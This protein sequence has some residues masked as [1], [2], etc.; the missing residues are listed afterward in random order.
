MSDVSMALAEWRFKELNRPEPW[1]EEA[2]F[3]R[4]LW[5]WHDGH[6]H[7]KHF[8]VCVTCMTLMQEWQEEDRAGKYAMYDLAKELGL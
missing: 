1:T 3:E 6:S 8:A 5:V 4:Q 7:E 2:E